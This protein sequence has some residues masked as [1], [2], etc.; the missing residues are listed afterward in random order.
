MLSQLT[1]LSS[2]SSFLFRFAH[3]AGIYS[4]QVAL[5]ADF[6][7]S[8]ILLKDKA[9]R[10]RS[11]TG[12]GPRKSKFSD[13]DDEEPVKKERTEEQKAK[14]QAK[15]EERAQ[16]KKEIRKTQIDRNKQKDVK[17]AEKKAAASAKKSKKKPDDFSDD[18]DE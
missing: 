11:T 9:T 1:R 7:T 13:D 16:K 15:R 6:H 17:L 10:L 8:R 5:R 12:T 14:L 4:S 18:E 3:P 2:I